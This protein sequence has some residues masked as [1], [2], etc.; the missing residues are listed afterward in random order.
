M[1]AISYCL[2]WPLITYMVFLQPTRMLFAYAFDG[3]LPASVAKTSARGHVPYVAVLV[4]AIGSIADAL[5]VRL[6]RR[7]NFFRILVYAILVQLISMALVGLAA[8]VFPWRRPEM[9][10]ASVTTRTFLGVPLVVIAGSAR[11]SRP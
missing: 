11:S 4:S 9:Y 1:L 5:V 10:I 3:L 7:L 6:Q 8:V 2:Y